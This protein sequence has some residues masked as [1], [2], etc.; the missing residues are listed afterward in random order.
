MKLLLSR[1][2]ASVQN[3]TFFFSRIRYEFTGFDTDFSHKVN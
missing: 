2:G 3:L 1:E